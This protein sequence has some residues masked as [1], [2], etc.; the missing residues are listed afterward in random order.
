MLNALAPWGVPD[1]E[2][3][4][5][6]AEIL[7][8]EDRID[9]LDSVTSD[10]VYLFSGSEDHTVVPPIVAAAAEFYAD[11]GL[12]PDQIKYVT[13]IS[14]GHAFVTDDQGAAC[15]Q[16]RRTLRRRLRLRSGRSRA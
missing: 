13:D 8:A 14:A 6:K 1:P 10:R 15:E 16:L 11:L 4:A 9:P 7:A 3:L 2:L 12:K 5:H